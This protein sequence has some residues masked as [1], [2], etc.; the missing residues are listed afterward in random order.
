MR[1]T[2]FFIAHG[3]TVPPSFSRGVKRFLFCPNQTLTTV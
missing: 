2:L 1:A 3:K